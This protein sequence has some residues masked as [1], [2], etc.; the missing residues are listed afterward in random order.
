[1]TSIL[2]WLLYTSF[3]HFHSLTLFLFPSILKTLFTSSISMSY[4]SIPMET[5]VS[6]QYIK[7]RTSTSLCK[8]LYSA[9]NFFPSTNCISN[10][11]PI[12]YSR[13][14]HCVQLSSFVPMLRFN[15]Y[16]CTLFWFYC[17]YLIQTL[18]PYVLFHYYK[19]LI[20]FSAVFRTL[21]CLPLRGY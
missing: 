17:Y 9:I 21:C 6:I 5:K 3:I 11:S 8:I 10:S 1:M 14:T 13:L 19:L 16:V 2:W 15:V 7:D 18:S 20:S 12:H 4:I